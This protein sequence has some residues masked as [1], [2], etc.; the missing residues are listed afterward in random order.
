MAAG[1][2]IR[3][4][5]CKD[6]SNPNSWDPEKTILFNLQLLDATLFKQILGMDPPETPVTAMAYAMYNMPFFKLYEQPSGIYGDFELKSVS[7]LDKALGAN[8]SMHE[9]E[10]GLEFPTIHLKKGTREVKLNRVD[11][12]TTFVPLEDLAI[13]LKKSSIS[14]QGEKA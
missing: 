5:I 1:G 7:Y 4:G 11:E 10:E 2:K 8:S 12:K 3:Q 14:P 9:E 6:E 13:R